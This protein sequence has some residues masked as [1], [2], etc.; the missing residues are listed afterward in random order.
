MDI[1]SWILLSTFFISLLSFV[2]VLTLS[3]KKKFLDKILIFMVALSA[4]ALMG[5]A[6]LHL[7]PEALEVHNAMGLSIG[8]L[9][10]F[11]VFF[12]ILGRKMKHVTA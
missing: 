1:L 9:F 3:L 8:I 5:G 11:S 12:L 6:F 7:I 2:G 4:G 10:G